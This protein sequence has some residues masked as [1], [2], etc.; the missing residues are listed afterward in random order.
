MIKEIAI[1]LMWLLLLLL[2]SLL[3]CILVIFYT[4][5]VVQVIVK[6]FK[7]GYNSND[8]SKRKVQDNRNRGGIARF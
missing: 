4:A 7:E 1:D 6:K 2:T 5:L 8:K 3:I